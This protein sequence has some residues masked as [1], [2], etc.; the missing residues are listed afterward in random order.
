MIASLQ[1]CFSMVSDEGALQPMPGRAEARPVAVRVC[2]A[3][4]GAVWLPGLM[5]AA[6]FSGTGDT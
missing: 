5:G 2:W 4:W 6:S 3:R 1:S